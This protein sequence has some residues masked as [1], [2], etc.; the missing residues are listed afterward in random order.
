NILTAF[1]LAILGGMGVEYGVHY[2]R[3]YYQERAQGR[4]HDQALEHAY[5]A[6]ARALGSAALTSSGAFLI[7]F[8]SE[9]RGFSELGVIAGFGILSIYLVYLLTFP[10][11]GAA[12]RR[13]PR[14]GLFR[15]SFGW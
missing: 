9:F 5:L 2:I 1:L 13:S 15:E 3:R 6:M 12:V 14:F 10:V 8:F 7:L 4:G 11:L